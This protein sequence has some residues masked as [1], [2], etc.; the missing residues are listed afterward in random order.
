MSLE[1]VVSMDDVV[2]IMGNRSK[3]A[4]NTARTLGDVLTTGGQQLPRSMNCKTRDALCEAYRPFNPGLEA[5]ICFTEE[6]RSRCRAVREWHDLVALPTSPGLPFGG[7]Q[8]TEH[9]KQEDPVHELGVLGEVI[10]AVKD[11]YTGETDPS[12]PAFSGAME[13]IYH[14]SPR[15]LLDGYWMSARYGYLDLFTA[16]HKRL[17]EKQLIC[18]RK[19][20]IQEECDGFPG[21]IDM[22][23]NNAGNVM[24]VA[25]AY[26]R[27]GIVQYCLSDRSFFRNS[28][29]Q[30]NE[31]LYLAIEGGHVNVVQTLLTNNIM[32]MW[33]CRGDT[34]VPI[35]WRKNFLHVAVCG[36]RRGHQVWEDKLGMPVSFQNNKVRAAY[37]ADKVV[38]RRERYEG[39]IEFLVSEIPNSN[40]L[41]AFK[42]HGLGNLA[43]KT[44]FFGRYS[45][46]NLKMVTLIC[47]NQDVKENLHTA[48]WLEMQACAVR[49]GDVSLFELATGPGTGGL[50]HAD[51]DDFLRT[52]CSL[53]HKALVTH[54]LP[55][56]NPIGE[57]HRLLKSLIATRNLGIMQV[58]L[59][60]SRMHTLDDAV[61]ALMQK[62][63]S[64]SIIRDDSKMFHI[65]FHVSRVHPT[66]EDMKNAVQYGHT[67]HLVSL[68]LTERNVHVFYRK[69]IGEV[70]SIST[71]ILE[72]I[73][74][75]GDVQKQDCFQTDMVSLL[76]GSI[77]SGDEETGK[78][79]LER[80]TAK[81]GLSYDVLRTACSVK[82]VNVGLVERL[83]AHGV[84]PSPTLCETVMRGND[85]D[86]IRIFLAH[87][88]TVSNYA[89]IV[90]KRAVASS[91]IKMAKMVR[92]A[93]TAHIREQY[94]T[95][96]LEDACW[97]AHREE[98]EL[99][100]KAAHTMIYWLRLQ[101]ASPTDAF[102]KWIGRVE[103]DDML[104]AL[105]FIPPTP[106][107]IPPTP[108]AIPQMSNYETAIQDLL[109]RAVRNNNLELARFALE[110][111]ASPRWGDDAYV[112][113][114]CLD[115]RGS[116][117][118]LRLLVSSGTYV[119]GE[120]GLRQAC[121]TAN[122][123]VIRFFCSHIVDGG[124]EVMR[125]MLP[126]MVE[127]GN[128]PVVSLIL[129]GWDEHHH[130][131]GTL[132]LRTACERGDAAM[133]TCLVEVHAGPVF[134]INA[135]EDM[136]EVFEEQWNRVE[137]LRIQLLLPAVPG[138][139][140]AEGLGVYN[141]S[142]ELAVEIAMTARFFDH[143]YVHN[144][145]GH[146]VD[147][148]GVFGMVRHQ[149]L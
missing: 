118:M 104:H 67:Y 34:T 86:L 88:D 13:L 70:R 62:M 45:P 69:A 72:C 32:H 108:T 60:D 135:D 59:R 116:V 124:R 76:L 17:I 14:A 40:G 61:P 74:N 111:G 90:L 147:E 133:V 4:R 30:W 35:L 26:G 51:C 129:N 27:I 125:E 53:N 63:L 48:D 143:P 12:G 49:N 142:C 110:Q 20:L 137:E 39:V 117:A 22:D 65:A 21:F 138:S 10:G 47:S 145:F 122:V 37:Y 36:A 46:A 42:P 119:V 123:N 79:V 82:T 114:V 54:L 127:A 106:T 105:T 18:Y 99:K 9:L 58:V 83:L 134:Y 140:E 130:D 16:I 25:C 94:L 43:V 128:V 95:V 68:M 107:A 126:S 100:Q 131:L 28:G 19:N 149:K 91:D 109:T 29:P 3:H 75:F 148:F 56:C 98:T 23:V 97:V 8:K 132:L 102:H 31:F 11:E 71:G 113:A 66:E 115:P 15:D 84:Q 78:F 136:K 50:D 141:N 121:R 120:T 73:C 87:F 7:F 85:F 57:D 112:N 64:D 144:Q 41:N 38:K 77:I 55:R 139:D 2:M 1:D 24:S 44:F 80:I 93:S 92:T 81:E 101:G 89:L 6:H 146:Y 103:H 33:I 52:A 96:L 5:S